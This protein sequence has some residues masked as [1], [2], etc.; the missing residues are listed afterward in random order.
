M[1]FPVLT[2][3][4][5]LNAL[6]FNCYIVSVSGFGSYR[7]TRFIKN[8]QRRIIGFVGSADCYTCNGVSL[9]G[10]IFISLKLIVICAVGR[11]KRPVVGFRPFRNNI[12]AVP[13]DTA[14]RT[15]LSKRYHGQAVR[16]PQRSARNFGVNG[17]NRRVDFIDDKCFFVLPVRNLVVGVIRRELYRITARIQ[18]TALKRGFSL[19]N[20]DYKINDIAINDLTFIDS[21]RRLLYASCIIHR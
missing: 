2:C 11:R 3:V 10:I 8:L 9:C 13:A 21:R 17:I 6:C 16:C 1:Q 7:H 4:N 20:C 19:I 15:A 14:R 12:A 18:R 5:Y